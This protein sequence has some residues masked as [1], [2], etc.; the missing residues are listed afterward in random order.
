LDKGSL[1]WGNT[2]ALSPSSYKDVLIATKLPIFSDKISVKEGFFPLGSMNCQNVTIRRKKGKFANREGPFLDPGAQQSS[3]VHIPLFAR[4][5][6]ISP[7][8]SETRTLRDQP[9]SRV[10]R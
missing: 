7:L 3:P 5:E 4:L 6:G 10:T 9:F 1:L 8:P 2:K